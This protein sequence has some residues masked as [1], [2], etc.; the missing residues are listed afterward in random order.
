LPSFERSKLPFSGKVIVLGGDLRQTLPIIEGDSRSEIVNSAIVN[1]YLWSHVVVFHLKTNMRLSAHTLT[2][3]GKKEL[4]DFS[5]WMLDM[6]E[7]NVEATTKEGE[8]EPTWIKI[9]E[10]FLLKTKDDKISCIVNI[11]YPNLVEKNMDFDYFRE[12]TI[13]TQTND[14]ADTINNYMVSLIPNDEKQYL[15]CDTILKTPNTHDSYDLLYPV[16]FLNSLSGNNFP[17]HK[18]SQKR[19]ASNAATKF[20]SS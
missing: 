2:V 13:L 8:S 4:A 14:I 15:S 11:V 17:Q 1:S 12:R 3:E 9:P 10:E 5:I 7:G 19:S 20:E 18:L 16:E 6:G